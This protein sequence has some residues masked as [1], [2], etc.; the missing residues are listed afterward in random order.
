MSKPAGPTRRTVLKSAG[1]VALAGTGAAALGA[2]T[3]ESR[4]TS[5][6][7]AKTTGAGARVAKADVPEGGG[8]ILPDADYVVTQPAAGQFKAFSKIC[9]HAG[10]PVGQIQNA[11]IICPCHGSH[12]SITDGSPVSGPAQKA[13]PAAKVTVSGADLVISG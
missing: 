9:T 12:F 2:C 8:V 7:A 11:E 3:T 4:I 13:L 6:S 10:C 1:L 5:P